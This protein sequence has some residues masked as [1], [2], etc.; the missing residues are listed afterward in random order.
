[1]HSKLLLGHL[2]VIHIFGRNALP[3]GKLYRLY[4]INVKRANGPACIQTSNLLKWGGGAQLSNFSCVR[5]FQKNL[6][7]HVDSFFQRL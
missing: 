5:I 2:N 6:K 4:G 1:M 7:D 3:S